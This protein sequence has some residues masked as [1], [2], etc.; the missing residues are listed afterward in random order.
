MVTAKS[1]FKLYLQRNPR[2]D[3]AWSEYESL[4]GRPIVSMWKPESLSVDVAGIYDRAGAELAEA[5]DVMGA[6]DSFRKAILIDSE[7][8]EPYF[9]FAR[10]HSA[11]GQEAEAVEMLRRLLRAD[12]CHTNGVL[13]AG[14]LLK[15]LG[16]VGEARE[17]YEAY[18]AKNSNEEVRSALE[19]AISGR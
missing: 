13:E 5:G 7:L 4:V 14:R 8:T 12:P 6:A 18:L 19:S 1:F 16:R 15:S 11:I 17:L 3:E 10:L 9:R 2:D